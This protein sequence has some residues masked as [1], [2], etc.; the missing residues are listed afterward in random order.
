MVRGAMKLDT[1]IGHNQ[2][3]TGSKQIGKLRKAV[4]NPFVCS[5]LAFVGIFGGVAA[6]LVGIVCVILHGIVPHDH[7]FDSVG[8]VLLIAAIP[9]I[10]IGSIFLDEIDI[11]RG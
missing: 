10:L 2:L 5:I 1:G 3:G 4:L 9:S 7:A 11:H 8:T 6:L